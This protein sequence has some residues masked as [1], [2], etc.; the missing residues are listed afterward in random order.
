MGIELKSACS[1]CEEIFWLGSAKAY[2]WLGFQFGNRQVFSWFARHSQPKCKV[3]ITNDFV[4]DY[5]CEADLTEQEH[6][7]FKYM[8]YDLSTHQWKCVY[9]VKI[10]N[11]YLDHNMGLLSYY[12]SLYNGDDKVIQPVKKDNQL[13]KALSFSFDISKIEKSNIDE[14]HIESF[15]N[16]LTVHFKNL[17]IEDITF[18]WSDWLSNLS[19]YSVSLSII[20]VNEE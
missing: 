5:P 3:Y 7:N 14:F 6:E 20:E 16:P 8:K 11:Y 4:S 10:E 15:K 19:S 12:P 17:V 13:I 9:S 1:T 18:E 2:K